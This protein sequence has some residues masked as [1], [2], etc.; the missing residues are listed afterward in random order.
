LLYHAKDTHWNN[1]GAVVG[2]E[3]LLKAMGTPSLSLLGQSPS[4]TMNW[5]GDLS[6]MLY[7]STAVYDKQ[8]NFVLPNAFTFTRAIRGFDDVE[9]ESVN[10]TKA[11]RL[12]MFRDSFANAL[13]RYLSDSFSQVDYSRVFPYDY[14]K[15]EADLP[16]VLVIEIA[17]RNINW[18]L[19]S[20]PILAI[21]PVYPTSQ[22][23]SQ[24][25]LSFKV[26]QSESSGFHYL[27]VRY[28]DQSVGSKVTAVKINAKTGEYAAFPLYQDGNF[29][30]DKIEYGF[31]LYT[32]E[33]IDLNTSDLLVQIDG[34]W[35]RVV[36]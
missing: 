8:F 19:Q 29:E 24:M 17:E 27:N 28:D 26:E 11:G 22:A 1:L 10:P 15:V 16:E 33:S 30:D 18:L 21:D 36:R 13:V 2:Y 34:T 5:Q 25:T 9:I 32:K 23:S 4:I 14:R 12:T 35:I 6:R 20:T 31:S 7:P 3:A